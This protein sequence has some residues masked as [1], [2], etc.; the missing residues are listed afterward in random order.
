VTDTANARDG[1]DVLAAFTEQIRRS[2]VPPGPGWVVEDLGRLVRTTGPAD[3][4]L[5]GFIEWSGLGGLSGGDVDA[6][7]AEQVAYFRQQ[8]A[9]RPGATSEW[10]HYDY[11]APADLSDRLVAAGLTR[12][13]PE[14]LIIGE[15]AGVLA[16]LAEWR[17][18]TGVAVR[19]V[20]EPDDLTA[21][22]G[23]HR[24][25]WSGDRSWL[26]DE[27]RAEMTARG[28]DV[29]IYFAD[30]EATGDLMSAAWIRFTPGTDFAGLWG[31][32]THPDHRRRGAYR[33]LV[34]VRASAAVD[35]GVRYV[36]VD[37]SPESEPILTR[38]GLRRLATTT[39]HTLSQS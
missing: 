9:E 28:D 17:P 25:V 15:T 6:V 36:Q 30:D 39:P 3:S 27:L 37:A 1:A 21:L 8:A 18:V 16:R 29:Q 20:T 34:E 4:H 7:I 38:L 31:G 26:V 12:E 22:L 2:L 23:L 5:G 14:A 10:K 13:D 24:A 32:S 11:D 33:S 35:R 19:R